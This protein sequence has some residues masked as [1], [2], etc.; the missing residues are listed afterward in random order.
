MRVFL[1]EILDFVG[2]YKLLGERT[3]KPF[4]SFRSL[5]DADTE[6]IT[7]VK[8]DLRNKN[9]CLMETKASLIIAPPDF[10]IDIP[11]K[12]KCLILV[13]NPKLIFV[14]LIK[15]F[16]D[17]S[18]V[19]LAGIHDSSIIS[20]DAQIG[21]GSYI[22]PF[23]SIG[24]AVIGKNA[25]IGA[26]CVIL[27]GV[28]IGDNVKIK[29][30][31]IIGKE[32]FGLAKNVQGEW[33]RFPHIGRVTIG[34]N[35]E[36]GAHV[37]IDRGTLGLTTIYDGVK[38]DDSCHIAHNISVGENTIIIGHTIIGGSTVI[39]KNCYISY[40][41]TILN[42]IIIHDNAYIGLGSVVINNISQGKRVFGNPAK[43]IE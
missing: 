41:V 35:V 2:N 42:G 12:N 23:C 18:D 33:E 26:S 9:K 37:S 38:I 15:K 34:N 31:T 36:I 22:G 19:T 6:S 43:K 8:I 16:F 1:K 39:G 13:E 5:K 17:D 40:G 27:D 20:S 14:R 30:F 7:W 29:S 11:L 21:E 32:G 25:K 4:T 10:Q 3:D 28:T 24:K